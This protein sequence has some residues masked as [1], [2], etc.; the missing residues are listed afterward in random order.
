MCIFD[1]NVL[2]NGS[3]KMSEWKVENARELL[4][5]NMYNR[6]LK[7]LRITKHQLPILPQRN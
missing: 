4:F 2:I 6:Q 7:A 5:C 1:G 3:R